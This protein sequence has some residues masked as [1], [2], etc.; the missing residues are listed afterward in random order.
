M[1]AVTAASSA[2]AATIKNEASERRKSCETRSIPSSSLIVS[3]AR[4]TLRYAFG[5]PLVAA[6]TGSPGRVQVAG[7]GVGLER[8][9]GAVVA[10]E[11]P[12]QPDRRRVEV[13]VLP[14]QPERLADAHA[15]VGEQ[16]DQCREAR[17]EAFSRFERGL[18]LRGESL[19]PFR[20][21]RCLGRS[22][23]CSASVGSRTISPSSRA[24]FS[25]WAE[26]AQHAVPGPLGQQR[27][28]SEQA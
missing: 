8:H 3:S 2:R 13:D 16:H 11:L 9:A 17:H 15:G 27:R 4:R 18:Q 19:R 26:R 12:A 6:M 10:G 1:T 14:A 24:I 20:L 21:E 23:G 5:L 28:L 22:C 7:A 25:T